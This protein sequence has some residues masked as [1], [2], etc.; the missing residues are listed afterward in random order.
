MATPNSEA[1]RYDADEAALVLNDWASVQ[2]YYSDEMNCWVVA[3]PGDDPP[4][5]HWATADAAVAAAQDV[6]RQAVAAR[7]DGAAQAQT[8]LTAALAAAGIAA[9]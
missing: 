9:A 2:L 6:L 3:V 5:Q 8:E 4:E 7:A 1:F